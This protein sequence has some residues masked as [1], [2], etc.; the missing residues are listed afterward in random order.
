MNASH[1]LHLPVELHLCVIEKLDFQDLISLASTN[2]YFRS[3]IPH[4]SHTDFLVAE[5]GI[6]AKNEEL[7]TCSGCACFRRS[8]QFADDMKK[9]KRA[10][11]GTEAA[12]RICLRCGVTRGLYVSG[13]PVV[14]YGR[15]H[16]LCRVCGTPTEHATC[17]SA[18]MRCAPGEQFFAASS[19]DP[20]FQRYA[21]RH[22][23][24]SRSTQS[25]NG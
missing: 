11:G 1:V 3:V 12:R 5:T 18:C 7:F 20:V 19:T 17:Q 2:R 10:R 14:I 22:D 6:W 23:G 16:V 13:T 15:A 8:K 21:P 4:P 9:G 24:P 25:T